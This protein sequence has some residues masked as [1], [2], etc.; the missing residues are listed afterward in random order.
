MIVIEEHP[1]TPVVGV[2]GI[3]AVYDVIIDIQ[4]LERAY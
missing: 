1:D 2:S 3:Y 4:V